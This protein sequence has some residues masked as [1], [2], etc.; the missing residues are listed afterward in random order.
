M[1]KFLII[2]AILSYTGFVISAVRLAILG[3]KFYS[4]LIIST[5]IT[6]IVNTFCAVFLYKKAERSKV[7]WALFGFIGNFTA[8]LCFW[9]FKDVVINWRRGK[10]SFS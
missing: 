9:L 6:T 4:Y 1:R 7:E 10:R 2:I 3:D 5:I 8:I